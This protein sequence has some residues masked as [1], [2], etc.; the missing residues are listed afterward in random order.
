LSR[1][2]WVAEFYEKTW[3]LDA[4]LLTPGPGVAIVRRFREYPD[5]AAGRLVVWRAEKSPGSPVSRNWQE[6]AILDAV[7]E[8]RRVS[9]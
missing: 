9:M 4:V 8:N 5:Y 7:K 6:C 3:G 1:A 2:W